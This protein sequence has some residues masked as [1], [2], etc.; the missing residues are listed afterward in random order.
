VSV[1]PPAAGAVGLERRCPRARSRSSRDP[2][3]TRRPRVIE[4]DRV[5]D[6]RGLI[7]FDRRGA[8]GDATTLIEGPKVNDLEALASVLVH[9]GGRGGRCLE[10]HLADAATRT[11]IGGDGVHHGVAGP[12]RARAVTPSLWCARRSPA[13]PR[14]RLAAAQPSRFHTTPRGH[15][16]RRRFRKPQ[17]ASLAR[18]AQRLTPRRS[19]W[20]RERGGGRADQQRRRLSG[21]RSVVRM[22]CGSGFR[23]PCPAM[24]RSVAAR[25]GPARPGKSLR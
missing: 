18:K 3:A 11:A 6:H 22:A 1:D 25:C 21:H 4:P 17:P 23:Q 2:R 5:V 13:R 9:P 10:R 19:G 20:G 16:L 12:T 7:V 15:R 24:R 8:P 14:G